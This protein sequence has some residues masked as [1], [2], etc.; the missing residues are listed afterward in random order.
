MPVVRLFLRWVFALAAVPPEYGGGIAQ[1]S[2]IAEADWA[3]APSTL[4]VT[5]L[6]YGAE[7]K[8]GR[9]DAPAFTDGWHLST[10]YYD[11]SGQ[12]VTGGTWNG[13]GT[14]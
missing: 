6:E 8:K 9:F 14:S 11:A 4:Q 2:Q 10:D 5:R 12:Y 3:N 1:W 7:V 13:K